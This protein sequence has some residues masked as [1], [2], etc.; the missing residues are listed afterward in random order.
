MWGGLEIPG[1]KIIEWN[2]RDLSKLFILEMRKEFDTQQGYVPWY[3]DNCQAGTLSARVLLLS[4][5]AQYHSH[6]V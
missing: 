1:I 2:Y 3:W 6:S 5:G 4:A